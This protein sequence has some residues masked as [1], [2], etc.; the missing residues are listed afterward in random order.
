MKG[1]IRRRG[2]RSWA[3]VLDAGRDATGRRCQR[4]HSVK[5]T[6]K[7]AERE[8]ARLLH[9]M[10]HGGYVEP[11]RLTVAEFLRKWLDDCAKPGVAKKTFERYEQ[12]V[13]SHLNP[14]IGHVRLPKL[15]PLQIQA[16]YSEK[17]EHGR[18]DGT[19]GLSP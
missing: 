13:V 8:L 3:I 14:A 12:L 6:R 1:H 10:N 9:E 19:G 5:G 11:S 17:L 4:W 2:A 15:H 7:D 18:K 16:C